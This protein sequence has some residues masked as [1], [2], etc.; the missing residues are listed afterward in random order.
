MK[1]HSGK[2]NLDSLERDSSDMISDDLNELRSTLHAT[3]DLSLYF[4]T[5]VVIDAPLLSFHKMWF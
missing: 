4:C 3:I 1:R 2:I 5:L